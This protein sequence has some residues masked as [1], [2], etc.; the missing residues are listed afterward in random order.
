LVDGTSVAQ[1]EFLNIRRDRAL[2]DSIPILNTQVSTIRRGVGRCRFNGED[3]LGDGVRRDW[4][5]TVARDI[6]LSSGFSQQRQG[7]TMI[8]PQGESDVLR[9]VG[10]FI[11]LSLVEG[12]QIGVKLP[13]S[14]YARLL[15]RDVTVE[16]IA[17][18]DSSLANSL[19]HAR[20][21]GDTEIVLYGV[22]IADSGFEDVVTVE[23]RHVQLQAALN[24]V[25]VNRQTERFETLYHG[26]HEILP[27]DILGGFTEE[28]LD[29]F[30]FGNPII[31]VDDLRNHIT[32]RGYDQDSEQIGWL[33]N[34]LE[35]L[36]QEELREFV[37]FVTSNTQLPFGGFGSLNPPIRIEAFTFVVDRDNY[38]TSRTC[39][40]QL[41]LP[42]Y[43]TFE[44]LR[45]GLRGAISV[46]NFAGMGEGIFQAPRPV[47]PVAIQEELYTGFTVAFS[48]VILVGYTHDSPQIEWLT[49]MMG[50]FTEQERRSVVRFVTG[51]SELPSG[52]GSNRRI[53]ISRVPYNPHNPMPTADQSAYQFNFPEY[54]TMDAFLLAILALVESQTN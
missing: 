17:E 39:F 16:M 33:F 29:N 9:T 22:P 15:D 12:V 38:P 46:N 54:P 2:W 26:F 52:Y 47:Q 5:T 25:G 49:Q 1:V 30:I 34:V 51:H 13:R 31:N 3:A 14:Y 19:R 4:F 40:H 45:D 23:N 32:L 11:A 36:S 20:D 41:N 35:G 7:L 28:D 44:S 6:F 27:I 43:P 50:M 24:N 37:R 42:I 10:R 48:Q 8:A 21:C 18:F 53:R